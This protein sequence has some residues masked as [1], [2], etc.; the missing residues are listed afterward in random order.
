MRAVNVYGAGVLSDTVS[1]R[2][3]NIPG[4]PAMV[5]VTLS[6]TD[7]IIAWVKPDENF[8]SITA[9]AI[10][11]RTHDGNWVTDSTNCDASQEPNFSNRNCVIPMV[12]I[13][14]LTSLTIDTMIKARVKAYNSNGW[15][16][17]SEPNIEGQVV[18][19]VPL[20]MDPIT[21]NLMT[22]VSNT[23]V[24]IGWTS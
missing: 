13:V 14:P 12:D 10:E 11:L 22:D 24:T 1:Q 18:H 7:I 8:E 23:E 19:T 9:Y 3:S 16:E 2:L 6:V 20:Q 4:K 21:T 15:G 5:T 17:P